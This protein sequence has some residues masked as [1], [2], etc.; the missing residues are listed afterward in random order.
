[1]QGKRGKNRSS[2]FG[3]EFHDD[4]DD[5]GYNSNTTNNNNKNDDAAAAAKNMN[6]NTPTHVPDMTTENIFSR[7]NHLQQLMVRLLACRPTGE[8]KGNRVV[9]VAL[10]SI[11]KE[12]FQIYYD[13]TEILG[14]LI[15][16]FMELEVHE[17]VK[18]HEIFLRVSKQFDELDN[19]YG[20][21]RNTGI[22][23]TSEYP[24]VEKIDMKKLDLMEEFIRDKAALAESKK[25][26]SVRV[27]EQPVVVEVKEPELVEEDMNAIK[28]LPAPEDWQVPAVEVMEEP[29]KEKKEE[30]DKINTQEEGD[31]LN[32]GDDAVTTEQHGN[33]LALALFDGV[34]TQNPVEP[35]WEA[36]K[37]ED[38]ADWETALVQ[39]ASGL[40]RQKTSLGGGFDMLLL[41][42]MYQQATMTQATKGGT[43][44][45]SGSASSVAFGSIGRPAMLALPAP[46]TS[47]NA[48]AP[49]TMSVDPFAA[50]LAVAPPTYVQMS[51]M[52][53]KQ[54]LLMEEQ[55][56]WQQYARE[57]MP[58]HLGMQNFQ[59][60][61][62]SYNN[63]GYT[64]PYNNGG[65]TRSY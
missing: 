10:Y 38:S 22:A 55:L 6:V 20:W 58:G 19:F 26:Q 47:S 43:F 15:E 46:P 12:S 51:E 52:D 27:E 17:C 33:Q 5:D 60:S 29:K 24:E 61:A 11:V 50:S 28:A 31:L 7:I 36:F 48:E 23:R 40:P 16:R 21:C 9:L 41:D 62:Y 14:I 34:P 59:G 65:Y 30:E 8:A 56:L 53:K 49:T 25:N 18:V 4:D 39:S 2:G 63:G 37:T 13:M 44:G 35:A 3:F 1:M 54:K 32:L 64:Y 42:G 45:A 57:G